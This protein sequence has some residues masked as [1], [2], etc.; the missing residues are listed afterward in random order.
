[1]STLPKQKILIE[2]DCL[3]DTRIGT[4]ASISQELATSVLNNGYHERHEDKY[5][6]VVPEQFKTLYAQRNLDTL[7]MSTITTFM[8]LLRHL[9]NLIEEEAISR[10]Y[11]SGPEVTVNLYPYELSAEDSKAILGAISKWLGHKV[12]I[13]LVRYAPSELRPIY[14]K[15]YSLIV[16]YNPTDWFNLNLEELMKK[17]LRDVALYI[18]RILH[19][20]TQTDEELKKIIEESMDPFQALDIVMK[21]VIDVS[22]LEVSYF[23]IVR[24]NVVLNFSDFRLNPQNPS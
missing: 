21:T 10:P 23:S 12:P 4:V 20:K 16:M 15:D 18:P 8:P 11:H 6:D 9:C 3:L 13:S 22:I 17:P 1:M 5:P 2:L 19:N 24:P 14:C 7:K